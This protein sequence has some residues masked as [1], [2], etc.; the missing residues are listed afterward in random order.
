MHV[1]SQANAFSFNKTTRQ[2]IVMNHDDSDPHDADD[3]FQVVEETRPKLAQP[4]LYKVILINDDY[5]PMEFVIDVLAK[6]FSHD[7]E[8]ATQ[9]ML[10]V[11]TQGKGVCGI[12]TKDVAETKCMQVNQHSRQHKHPLLCEVEPVS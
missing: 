3:Q 12:Y 7:E 10:A 4:K 1:L 6:F 8:Q 11:H 5:T 9:I 2:T